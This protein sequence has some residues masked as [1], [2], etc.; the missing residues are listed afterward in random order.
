VTT[1]ASMVRRTHDI[2][3]GDD[4]PFVV[5]CARGG[6][7]VVES[8]AEEWSELCADAAEDQPF[9]RPEWM[10][11]YLRRYSNPGKIWLLTAKR[12]GRLCLL[13]TLIEQLG[14]FA[15]VPIRKLCSPVNSFSGRF[16]AVRRGDPDGDRAIP[17]VWNHLRNRG[18]WDL[19]QFRYSPAGST[20]ER[21]AALAQTDGYPTVHECDKPNPLIDL[22]RQGSALSLM[23]H[24]SK[25]RSQLKQLRSRLSTKGSIRFTRINTADEKALNRFYELEASGWKGKMRTCALF[26]GSKNFYDEIATN[27]ARLGYFALYTLELDNT[28]LAAHFAFLYRGRCYSPKVAYNEAFKSYAPGHLIITDILRDCVGSGVTE[29]DITGEDHPWKMK[30]ATRTRAIQHHF[31]FR[32]GLGKLAHMVRFRLGPALENSVLRYRGSRRNSDS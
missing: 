23:P 15:K 13:L 10:I 2:P 9:Y 5:E 12:N 24:N 17:A 11:A 27:A 3:A 20:L 31:V 7:E 6:L 1:A 32:G 21:L 8:R 14:T 4:R 19:L 18:G 28:L 30:W 25:L 22:P 26:D 29:Y 16:D